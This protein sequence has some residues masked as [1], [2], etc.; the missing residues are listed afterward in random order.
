MVY[1]LT[2][3]SKLC[4]GNVARSETEAEHFITEDN[5]FA[6]SEKFVDLFQENA[7]AV[8]LEVCQVSNHWKVIYINVVLG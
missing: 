8:N 6:F 5:V 3:L 2:L 1:I 4:K 7:F